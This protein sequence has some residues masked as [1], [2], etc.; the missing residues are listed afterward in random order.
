MERRKKMDYDGPPNATVITVGERDV[1]VSLPQQ[2]SITSA[3]AWAAWQRLEAA[4][5]YQNEC[6]RMNETLNLA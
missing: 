1:V 5:R 4:Q 3:E 2:E 6:L